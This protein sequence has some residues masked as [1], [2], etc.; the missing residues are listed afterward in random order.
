MNILKKSF[1]NMVMFI[2]VILLVISAGISNIAG[3]NIG[4]WYG[5]FAIILVVFVISV[6]SEI[7][8]SKNI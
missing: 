4:M 1:I 8:E 5:I 6:I 3:F 2:V 7:L